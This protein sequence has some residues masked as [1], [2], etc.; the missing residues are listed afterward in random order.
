MDG[1]PRVRNTNAIP[2]VENV[3]QDLESFSKYDSEQAKNVSGL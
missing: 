2:W 1:L 3:S